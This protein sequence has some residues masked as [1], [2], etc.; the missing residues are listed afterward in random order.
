VH[1]VGNPGSSALGNR[2]YFEG[3]K[4]GQKMANG[5]Y[6]Y[7]SSQYIIGLKGE[8][9]R[10]IPE[11]EEA[12]HASDGVVNTSSIGIEN[13]HPDWT[14]KFLPETEKSL[15]ELCADI[16]KRY[17]IDPIKGIL[18]H[19][20]IP[21]S[22]KKRCPA[23]WVDHPEDFE[24]FKKEVQKHMGIDSQAM[25][26]QETVNGLINAKRADNKTAVSLD[27]NYW[28]KVFKGEI[29]ATKENIMVIMRRLLKLE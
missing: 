29:V 23:Y 3:L 1:Y 20:D 28:T 21:K 4:I 26:I 27:P 25:K 10:C 7:A 5:N 6:R 19:Y 24:R 15:V 16:C 9:I 13:C 17:N 14:G 11:N 12:I 8:I 18:R 2:N 22:N